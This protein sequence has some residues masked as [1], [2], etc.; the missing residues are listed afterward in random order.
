MFKGSVGKLTK[1]LRLVALKKIATRRNKFVN[2]FGAAEEAGMAGKPPVVLWNRLSTLQ[3][4]QFNWSP[5]DKYGKHF[6]VASSCNG[7]ARCL[8]K[9]NGVMVL[10]PYNL[11]QYCV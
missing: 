6:V 7:G 9:K 11:V 3:L 8:K 10:P 5:L 4:L 2:F 1:L